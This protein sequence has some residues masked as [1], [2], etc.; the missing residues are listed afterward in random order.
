MYAVVDPGFLQKRGGG[1]IVYCFEEFNWQDNS[2][3]IKI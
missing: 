2:R 3:K 1:G